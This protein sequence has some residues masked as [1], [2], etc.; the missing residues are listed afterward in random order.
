V[1]TE[2]ALASHTGSATVVMRTSVGPYVIFF[3]L[4]LV[5]PI[6]IFAMMGRP[7]TVDRWVNMFELFGTWLAVAAFLSRFRIVLTPGHLSYRAPLRGER[8][9]RFDEIER[10]ELKLGWRK[11]ALTG[12]DPAK[13]TALMVHPI[14]ASGVPPI[15]INLKPFSKRAVNHLIEFIGPKMI[16]DASITS[17]R[18]PQSFLTRARE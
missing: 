7:L 1:N 18:L 16:G 17:W 5:L 14:A 12:L 6:G 11:D 15:Q 9:V 2:S 8:R 10:T 3:V 13:L 4:L